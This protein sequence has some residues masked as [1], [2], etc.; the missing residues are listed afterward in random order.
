MGIITRIIS[1][2]RINGEVT[3][4]QAG[5]LLHRYLIV[6]ALS[7]IEGDTDFTNDSKDIRVTKQCLSVLSPA[8]SSISDENFIYRLECEESDLS[9]KFLLPIAGALGRN[10]IFALRGNLVFTSMDQF[11]KVLRTHGLKRDEI[12]PDLVKVT[13]RLTGGTYIFPGE[14]DGQALSGLLMALPLLKD[15]SAVMVE[16]K[17]QSEMYVDMT[18]D[19]MRKAG[20]SIEV[21]KDQNGL[22]RIYRIPGGQQYHLDENQD[23]QIEGDWE[24]AAYWF[25]G[26]AVSRGEVT[27]RNLN[28]DSLQGDR[29]ILRILRLFGVDIS[30]TQHEAPDSYN[31]DEP[32]YWSDV[33]INA[34][35][36][37]GTNID[38][39][40][41]PDLLAHVVLLA[42][43]ADGV[44]IIKNAAS[45]RMEPERVRE[46][47][48]LMTEL[49]AQITEVQDGLLIA[50]SGG[51]PLSGGRVGTHHDYRLAMMAAMASGACRK[52]VILENSD[53]VE[54]T[55]PLFFDELEKLKQN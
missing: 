28:L 15:K 6:R 21:Q 3:V 33:R 36:L 39:Y 13:G 52:P 34:K 25:T 1:N 14:S 23:K 54:R 32:V 45:V 55:Y 19:I 37:K 16:K 9:Y 26:A 29:R 22:A 30:E 53:A 50:G 24:L 46:M 20:I 27:C 31:G 48:A 12:R 11:Y 7:G 2:D 49:G 8:G 41:I 43:V 40:D 38:A 42:S 17:P 5:S 4:P 35:N 10:C 51:V 18:I 47:I 44:S